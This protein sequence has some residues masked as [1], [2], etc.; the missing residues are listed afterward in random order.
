MT[1]YVHANELK[2]EMIRSLHQWWLSKRAHDIPYRGEFDPIDFKKLLPNIM[3]ADIEYS[4]FRVRYRVVGTKVV[5]ATGFEFTGRYL[6]ELIPTA[7]EAPWLELYAQVCE[8]RLP[9]I[10]TSSCMTKAG[11]LF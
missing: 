5:E 6:D 8:A 3:I 11:E 2:S 4:P 10:G 9:V 7:P 1:I